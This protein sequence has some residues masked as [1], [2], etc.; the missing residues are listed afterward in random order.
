M[1]TR[2]SG[3]MGPWIGAAILALSAGGCGGADSEAPETP[4]RSVRSLTVQPT[5]A[6]TSRTFAGTSRSSLESRLSFKVS[7]TLQE[8]PIEVGD[9]LRQGALVARLDPSL[10]ALEAQR[11]EASLVQAQ[12]AE[13]NARAAYNRVKGLYADN[14]ATRNDLDTARANAESAQAQVDAAARQLELARLN[15]SYTELRAATDCTVATVGVEVNENVGVGNTIA[16]VNCGDEL[17]VEM[18]VPESLIGEVRRGMPATVEFDAIPGVEMAATVSEVGVSASGSAFPVTVAIE[19]THPRLRSGLAAEV[20]LQFAEPPSLDEH[21]ADRTSSERFLVPLSSLVKDGEGSF[22][23]VLEGSQ[24]GRATV[25]RRQVVLG[26]LT[27]QGVEVLSGLRAG[28]RVVTAGTSV[29]RDG[30]V[31]ADPST[32]GGPTVGQ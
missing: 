4:L 23:F 12:A 27:D 25:H 16:S 26:E 5:S 32:V 24:D 31:V 11:A 19:G 18:S 6:G 2:A 28:D 14:N 29:M 22:V 9:T 20:R 7:G 15:V 13:R 17:E 21:V 1:I 10:Y 30:L 8:L 3:R